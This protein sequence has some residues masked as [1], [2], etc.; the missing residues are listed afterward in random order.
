MTN[1]FKPWAKVKREKEPAVLAP[2]QPE[3]TQL[4]LEDMM[5]FQ[6]KEIIKGHT[7]P[8]EYFKETF[9]KFF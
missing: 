8:R 3:M 9:K 7:I 6:I 5:D 4:E 2:I 1:W